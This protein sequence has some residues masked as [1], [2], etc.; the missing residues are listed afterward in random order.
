MRTMGLALGALLQCFDWSR[1]EDGEVDMAACFVSFMFK[2]VE[3][4]CFDVH[5]D[6]CCKLPQAVSVVTTLHH[7]Q[8][9]S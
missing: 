7:A 2:A 5:F 1:V 8:W 3:D 6:Q 9:R 4:I